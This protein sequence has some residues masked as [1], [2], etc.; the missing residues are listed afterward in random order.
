MIEKGRI[1]R[2]E[3]ISLIDPKDVDEDTAREVLEFLNKAKDKEEIA[4]FVEFEGRRDV[5]AKIA[6]RILAKREEVKEFRSLEDVAE[7]P[8]IGPKRLADII[9]AVE[10][11]KVDIER[12]EFKSLLLK[13]PNYFGNIK[14]IAIEPVKPKQNDTRYEELRCVGYNPKFERLEAIVHIKKSYGYGSSICYNGTLEYVRFYIDWDND[15]NWE[16]LG[17]ASFRAY[18]IPGN[19]PLEYS[20]T[21]KLDTTKKKKICSIENL[22]RVRAI[23]SWNQVP[24]ENDPNYTPVWGNSK[25]ARIQIDKRNLIITDILTLDKLEKINPALIPIIDINKPL[26]GKELEYDLTQLNELYKE[27]V[28]VSRFAFP[29]VHKMLY[30][31]IPIDKIKPDIIKPEIVDEIIKLQ[32]NTR[33]EELTCLGYNRDQD[34]LVATIKIKQPSGYSG[35]LCS[36]GSKEYVAFWAD[37]GSGWEYVGST[38]VDVYDFNIPVEGLDY[39]V[40][41]PLNSI[42]KRQPCWQGARLVNVR[43]ILS[44]NVVPNDPNYNPHWG[45][46]KDTTIQLEP[47]ISATGHLPVIQSVGGMPVAN[48][49]ANGLAN[50][51]PVGGGCEAIDAPFG[52][53]VKITGKIANP[54]DIL[55]GGATQLQYRVYVS[56]AGITWEQLTNKFS[57]WYN[58]LVNGIWG[59]NTKYEQKLDS[60]GWYRYIEDLTGNHQRHITENVLAIWHTSSNGKY[61]IKVEVRDPTTNTIYTSSVVDIMVNNKAPK[62]SITITSGGGPCADFKINDIIEGTYSAYD[63]D[64]FGRLTITVEPNLGGGQF[65]APLPAA[66][67]ITRTYPTVSTNGENGIWKLDTNGMPKCGYIV[68]IRVWDRT[69]VNNSSCNHYHSSDVVGLCL[70]E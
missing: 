9:E 42:D 70:R 6:E 7:I 35:N 8:M 28:S 61:K 43:A 46:R 16:D 51:T 4:D 54:P 64:Y 34:E 49:D 5:G 66:S 47:G 3:T 48:I 30:A 63:T 60:E 69:I 2:R 40:H 44:W 65:I 15:G 20:V 31:N 22:P 24:M 18:N 52:G 14:G 68:R 38:S 32:Q 21:L 11:R 41:L 59:A 39:A 1:V 36:K 12:L 37:Y 45:N 26:E 57:I 53:V 58:D 33:Y 67:T 29:M 23:L 27:K 13:N 19:K 17:V 50:G 25:D 56:D 62:S 55:G 10:I